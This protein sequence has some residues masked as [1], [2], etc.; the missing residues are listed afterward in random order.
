LN[1][2]DYAQAVA[3][4]VWNRAGQGGWPPVNSVKVSGWLTVRMLAELTN[5]APRE[6][7]LDVIALAT[8]T[9]KRRA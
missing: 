3:W 2:I 4:I 1:T 6:V 9:Q 5:R 7:A 8:H